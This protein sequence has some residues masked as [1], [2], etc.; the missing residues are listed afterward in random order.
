M[1]ISNERWEPE[2]L[3]ASQPEVCGQAQHTA[4][5]KNIEE[6]VFHPGVTLNDADCW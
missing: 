6:I 4:F 2:I 1:A 3:C 5:E